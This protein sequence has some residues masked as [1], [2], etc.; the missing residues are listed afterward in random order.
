MHCARPWDESVWPEAVSAV[1]Q[2]WLHARGKGW[3]PFHGRP[4][5]SE[6]PP[7]PPGAPL[8]KFRQLGLVL[9]C[10]RAESRGEL[11][12]AARAPGTPPV[13][14]IDWKGVNE[15]LALLA[16]RVGAGE[17]ELVAPGRLGGAGGAQ[18]QAHVTALHGVE[19]PSLPNSFR[20]IAWTA[21][22]GFAHRYPL[23]LGVGVLGLRLLV[24]RKTLVELRRSS[25]RPSDCAALRFP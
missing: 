9:A 25:L 22:I 21:G 1:R 8:P 11:C 15:R 13:R 4:Q 12:S 6:L 24:Y 16:W 2:V 10:S 18:T 3:Q 17:A 7:V 19:C 14:L 5:L 20:S 23:I